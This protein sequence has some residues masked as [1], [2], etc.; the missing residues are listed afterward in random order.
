MDC[1]DVNEQKNPLGLCLP[2]GIKG[3]RD[4]VDG[5]LPA[6]NAQIR[7][8]M[9]FHEKSRQDSRQCILLIE[10]AGPADADSVIAAFLERLWQGRLLKG[11]RRMRRADAAR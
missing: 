1:R 11:E 9:C 8:P 2:A 4:L 3:V 10:E 5:A 6:G 7:P